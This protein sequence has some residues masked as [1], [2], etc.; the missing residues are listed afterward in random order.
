MALKRL[1]LLLIVQI[2]NCNITITTAAEAELKVQ[3]TAHLTYK[4]N[5]SIFPAYLSIRV[6]CQGVASMC[7]GS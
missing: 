2:P 6:D 5:E 1:H 4:I 7:V 3:N